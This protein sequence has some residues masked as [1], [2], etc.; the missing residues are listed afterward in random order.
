[1]QSYAVADNEIST[2]FD[3][4]TEQTEAGH[5]EFII[6]E[7]TDTNSQ[8]FN[9]LMQ[10]RISRFEVADNKQRFIVKQLDLTGY[11]LH[12]LIKLVETICMAVG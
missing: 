6:S 7:L 2:L 9:H 3:D 12:I 10:Q 5:D 1:M 11:M 4:R 8:E